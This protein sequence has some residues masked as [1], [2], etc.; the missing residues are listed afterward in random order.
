MIS[1]WHLGLHLSCPRDLSP[2]SPS[3]FLLSVCMDWT[4]E[5]ENRTPTSTYGKSV[6]LG[7]SGYIPLSGRDL[8]VV[9]VLV[10]TD[11][12][13]LLVGKSL[14]RHGVRT[15][16]V[17]D[18][19]FTDDPILNQKFQDYGLPTGFRGDCVEV[20]KRRGVYGSHLSRS[21]CILLVVPIPPS[22]PF[23]LCLKLSPLSQGR[24]NW[25]NS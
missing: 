4:E 16:C 8:P 7:V 19:S 23:D 10:V 25:R 6:T 2:Y 3:V 9:T 20:I 13:S 15:T 5:L 22:T 11:I 17:S 1:L 18:G 24:V 12:D 21:R 14:W